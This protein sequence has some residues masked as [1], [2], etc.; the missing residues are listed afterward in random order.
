MSCTAPVSGPTT[1]PR[2]VPMPRVL[3]HQRGGDSVVSIVGTLFSVKNLEKCDRP[4]S[5]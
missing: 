1:H 2:A 4:T 5:S 3:P